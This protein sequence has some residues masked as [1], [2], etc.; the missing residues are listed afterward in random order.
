MGFV[1]GMTYTFGGVLPVGVAL[2]FALLS[3]VLYL[4]I[5]KWGLYVASG[6]CAKKRIFIHKKIKNTSS[7]RWADEDSSTS[8][9]KL[10]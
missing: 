1:A 2:I 5:R 7:R 8:R 3:A 6:F 4:F 10:L 9:N